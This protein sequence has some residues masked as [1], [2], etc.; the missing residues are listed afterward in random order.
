MSRYQRKYQRQLVFAAVTIGFMV[1][2]LPV[3]AGGKNWSTRIG[4]TMQIGRNRP[5]VLLPQRGV[6]ARRIR[7][8]ERK[9]SIR[10]AP[11]ESH[12]KQQQR[13]RKGV[14]RLV[15]EMKRSNKAN[16]EKGVLRLVPERK[17]KTPD[18]N[19]TAVLEAIKENHRKQ[20]EQRE[21][22]EAIKENHRKQQQRKRKVVEGLFGQKSRHG[23][24]GRMKLAKP[25]PP[26]SNGK[27]DV[28][29][30]MSPAPTV[31]GLAQKSAGKFAEKW[32]YRRHN[33]RW[34]YWMSSKRWAVW[35]DN[36]WIDSKKRESVVPTVMGL[37]S[38]KRKPDVPTVMSPEPTVM[39]LD[40]KSSK[41]RAQDA[42][43]GREKDKKK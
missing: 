34:W 10:I 25:I 22:L 43:K 1:S 13:K 17:T 20:E 35:D 29:T 18:S 33:G 14:L 24:L 30:A 28:P 16:K 4:R 37:D 41:K 36:R 42:K 6:R 11:L 40:Q 19:V 8:P 7:R 39:G 2:S 32:R 21:V 15:P 38:K 3:V 5:S 27:P 23:A 31:M 9:F 12:R 26:S